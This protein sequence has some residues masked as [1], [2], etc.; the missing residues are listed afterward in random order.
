MSLRHLVR[1]IVLVL[2]VLTAAS[3]FAQAP[4]ARS[5]RP[6]AKPAAQDA[7]PEDPA[8]AAVLQ[9]KPAAPAECVKAA[10]VLADLGRPDLAKGFVK[11]ALDANLDQNQLADLG[12][13]M[14][15]KTFL[16]LGGLAALQPEGKRL[17][18]AVIAALNARLQDPKRIAALV[19]QL[20]ASGENERFR[21]ATSLQQVGAAAVGPL[22]AVLADP[23]R[24][25]EH[26]NVR[27]VLTEM[28]RAARGPLVAVVEGADPKLAVEAM[29]VLGAA[30]DPSV[31][32][33]M[34]RARYADQ[35]PLMLRAAAES[36]LERLT[37][38]VPSRAKAVKLL[39]DSARAYFDR[40]QTPPGV[41]DGRVEQWSWDETLRR[42]V[43]RDVTPA[44]AARTLA[45]RRASD[46]YVIAP[47]EPP[48]RL[49][50]L[51]TMLE[52]AAYQKGLDRPWDDKSQ[53]LDEAR[54]FGVK[55]IEQLL[56]DAM[57]HGHAAAAAAAARLLGE[58]G[59][60]R[61][62]LAEGAKPSP[63]AVAAQNADRRLRLA[64]VEAIVRLQPERPF[65]GSSYVLDALGF[66]AASSGERGALV[67]CPNADE[68]RDLAGMLT[69]AGYR[70]RT[71]FDGKDLLYQASR[72]ADYE[73]ALVDVRIDHPPVASLVQQLRH[74]SRTASLR[75]GLIAAAGYFQRAEHVA[76]S[77]PLSRAF[78]RPRDPKAFRWQLDE[79]A[80]IDPQEVVSFETRQRQAARALELLAEL[81]R[82]SSRLYDVRRVQDS[83]LLTL[84]NPRL[85]AKAVAVL[86][87]V[88]S[89][90]AQRALLEVASR[91][92][93]P[94]KLRQA[95]SA[96]FRQNVQT[97]GILLT[98]GEIRRQYDRYNQSEKADRAT[99]QLLGRILDSLEASPHKN[100]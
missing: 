39:T 100:P 58:M 18:D 76:K 31:A 81:G 96:A 56:E 75:V 57:A 23:A 33:A 89:A 70:V 66:L 12:E 40:H 20:Q 43:A 82:S 90:E 49:L 65:A 63:L 79:L 86:A 27:I 30:N 94:L 6:A 28:G 72:S 13:Q 77:D 17:S 5:R 8:V 7:L 87:S 2:A 46:A 95:A 21:A 14:G 3:A 93:R 61:E 71:C 60:A 9:T 10:R 88:N 52:A 69:A 98:A 41:V 42:A 64:A 99:Q 38:S 32:C 50:Y 54:K 74:D 26:A 16:D 25:A 80:A 11:K 45:A 36:E 78:S 34:L 62:L 84:V 44:E 68:A 24:S 29:R 35:S 73:L 92:S 47:E 15:S 1:S 19:Q 22:L 97:H 4:R 67:G 59:T 55:T 51:A 53:P 85:A 91:P 37:G 48:V 83:V